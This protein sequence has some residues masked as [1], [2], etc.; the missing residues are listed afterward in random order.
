M[1]HQLLRDSDWAGMAHSLE[2]R[3]PLVD[4]TLFQNIAPLLASANPPG[5]RDM[6]ISP[7]TPLPDEVLAR[8]KTGF[9]VPV[10]D[11]L[12]QSFDPLARKERGLR[13]W[14][15]YVHNA[16]TEDSGASSVVLRPRRRKLSQSR[17]PISRI[18]VYRIGQLGDTIVRS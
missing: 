14:A 2:I 7:R 9:T 4:T 18:I 8:R 16:F 12:L 3:V 15:R 1:R 10:R 5:K 17:R 6:A 13:G 11:W